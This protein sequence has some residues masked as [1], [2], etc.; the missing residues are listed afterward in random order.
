MFRLRRALQRDA[1]HRCRAY[2]RA[3]HERAQDPKGLRE[4]LGLTRKGMEAAAKS[5]I[6]ASGWMRDHLAEAV[7]LHVADVVWETIN[8][9]LFLDSS[10]RWQGPPREGSWWDFTKI[11][12]RARSHTKTKPKWETWRLVGTLNGHLDAYRHPELAETVSTGVNAAAQPAG[13]LVLAQPA[14]LPAPTK[15]TGSWWA[16]DGA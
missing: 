16:H 10:G 4:R 15:P 2:W 8:R 5:H 12:G 6:E 13:T 14:R 9:H 3:H 1:Q 7:G 11:P